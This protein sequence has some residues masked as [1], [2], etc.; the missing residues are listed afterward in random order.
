MKNVLTGGGGLT[1]AGGLIFAWIDY[2]YRTQPSQTLYLGGNSPRRA[3]SAPR[4]ASPS[5][6][7]GW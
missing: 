2:V 7:P 5:P 4:G 6:V 3:G 1:V